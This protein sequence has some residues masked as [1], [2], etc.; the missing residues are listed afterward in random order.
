MYEVRDRMCPF[1]SGSGLRRA[2]ALREFNVDKVAETTGLEEHLAF[3]ILNGAFDAFET[4]VLEGVRDDFRRKLEE[5][6]PPAEPEV[7]VVL[8]VEP[9]SVVAVPA[10]PT[11]W[12]E[13]VAFFRRKA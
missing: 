7:D 9:G 4:S 12:G 8:D 6:G 3:G 5:L 10:P 11:L 1:P 13:L 2:L